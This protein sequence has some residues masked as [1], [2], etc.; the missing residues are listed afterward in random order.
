MV[1]FWVWIDFWFNFSL[2]LVDFVIGISWVVVV[3]IEWWLGSFESMWGRET[4]ESKGER[5]N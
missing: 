5:K 4:D 3:G 1:W 2:F